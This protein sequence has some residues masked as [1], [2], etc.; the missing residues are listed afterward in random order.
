MT[1]PRAFATESLWRVAKSRPT[2]RKSASESDYTATNR[3][4]IYRTFD[5]IPLRP[6][7][8]LQTRDLG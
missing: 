3:I 5:P 8:L 1:P 4:L 6:Q 7:Q 2:A